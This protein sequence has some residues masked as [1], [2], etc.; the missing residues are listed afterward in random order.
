MSEE[1]KTPEIEG[2]ESEETAPIETDVTQPEAPPP[3]SADASADVAEAPAGDEKPDAAKAGDKPKGEA[4]KQRRKPRYPALMRAF[5]THQPVEGI[6]DKVIKGGYEVKVGKARG[7]CPHSQIAL[8]REDD[9]ES[10]VGQTH[11]FRIMQLRRGGEDL[12]LSRRAILDDRRVEEA[13]AVRATLIEGTVM[14]GHVAGMA[15][16]GAFVDLGAG[17]QGLVHI[18]ELSHKRVNK[19]EDAVKVGDT[20]Q[21]KVLKVDDKKGRLSLSIRA[22]QEDPWS[23][24]LERFPTGSL[25]PGQIVRLAEF[26]AFVEMAPGLEALAPASEFPPSPQAW[27]ETLEVGST[28][29]WYVL[30]V[31]P[32]ERRFSITLP[33]EGDA[34]AVVEVNST[35][36][37]KVQRIENYGVFVWLAPGKVGLMPRAWTGAPAGTEMQRRFS[38]GE[39][40]EVTVVEIAEEGRRIRLTRKGVEPEA[41][42]QPQRPRREPRREPREEYRPTPKDEPEVPFGTSLADKLRAALG[43]TDD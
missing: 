32:K 33:G 8:E 31:N 43:Q 1:P 16:F 26:G 30:S 38:I 10:H 18:S 2:A 14:Q 41:P 17:V 20:V 39:A 29:D 34:A 12:V 21:V 24:I 42:Q 40:V 11:Q 19:V 4:P 5:R 25:H 35:L 37:G 13:K 22:A 15:P 28:R 36:E 6:I 9:P 3:T 27:K 7:F 23:G